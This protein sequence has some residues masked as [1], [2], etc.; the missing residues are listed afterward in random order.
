MLNK[1]IHTHPKLLDTEIPQILPHE[2]AD[3][4][5]CIIN[6]FMYHLREE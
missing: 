6:L 5:T 1:P 4:V 2:V 3:I